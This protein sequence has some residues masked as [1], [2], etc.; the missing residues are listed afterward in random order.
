MMDMIAAY[1]TN[2]ARLQRIGQIVERYHLTWCSDQDPII[3]ILDRRGF[4]ALAMIEFKNF[5]QF[6]NEVRGL[7]CKKTKL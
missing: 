4:N 5:V 3:E 1:R 2:E 7:L 6:E